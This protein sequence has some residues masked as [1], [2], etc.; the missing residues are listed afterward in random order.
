[1]DFDYVVDTNACN[2]QP[3][4]NTLRSRMHRKKEFII[5]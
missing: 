1:M 3:Y 5:D 2:W 4:L